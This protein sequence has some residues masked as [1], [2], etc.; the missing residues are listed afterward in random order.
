MTTINAYLNFNG[1]CE[2]VFNFY[3]SVFGAGELTFTRFKD[4]HSDD[5][6]DSSEGEKIMHVVLPIGD[7]SVLMGSDTI[8]AMGR[9]TFGTNFSL[10]VQANSKEHAD[11]L[12]NQLV[13][14]GQV[15]MPMAQ[16]P[17]GAYF[18]M[19]TDQFGIQWM[20]NCD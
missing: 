11:T 2:E 8:E 19:L 7:G 9:T 14:G 5:L 1:N 6:G 13:A 3:A 15:T 18:G 10:A 12:Y 4:M 20:V 17:W 16:A